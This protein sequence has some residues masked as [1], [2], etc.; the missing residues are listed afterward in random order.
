M[1]RLT[2]SRPVN[3]NH[4]AELIGAGV[5]AVTTDGRTTLTADV[6]EEVLRRAVA[7]HDPDWTPPARP[8]DH[9]DAPALNPRQ[10]VRA[11]AA[12]TGKTPRQVAAAFREAQG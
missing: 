9:D 4:V 6:D 12:L 2:V 11:L 10:M 8:A 7:D 5:V 3:V 1:G